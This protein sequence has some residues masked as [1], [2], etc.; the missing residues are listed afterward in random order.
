MAFVAKFEAPVNF[1][2]G[3]IVHVPPVANAGATLK[4]TAAAAAAPVKAM[5]AVHKR[6]MVGSSFLGSFLE[7]VGLCRAAGNDYL[8]AHCRQG[9]APRSG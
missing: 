9:S 7:S 5:L 8:T 1:P 4:P 3:V 2:W 6:F